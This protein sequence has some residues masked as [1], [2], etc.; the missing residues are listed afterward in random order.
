MDIRV[1]EPLYIIHQGQEYTVRPGTV[2]VERNRVIFFYD[3][4]RTAAVGYSRDYCLENP[5]TFQVA[6][7]LADREV[8]IRDVAKV[9]EKF[10]HLAEPAMRMLL[11]EI[12]SL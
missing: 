1:K 4:T 7:T 12:N 9:I 10:P 5:Q 11:D 8:P 6:R 2:G 3:V